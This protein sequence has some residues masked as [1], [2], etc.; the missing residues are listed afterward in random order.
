MTTRILWP[1]DIKA[2][3]GYLPS[4]GFLDVEVEFHG[5]HHQLCFRDLVNAEQGLA[6]AVAA[7]GVA[8]TE[9]G[10]VL[11]S[12]VSVENVERAVEMLELNGWFT[13][14]GKR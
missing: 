9:P 1:A 5:R 3:A 10:L 14:A 11:L 13:A 8:W 4:K 12:E 6:G 2:V 7:G